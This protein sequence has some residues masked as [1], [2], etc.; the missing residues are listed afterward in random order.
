MNN[1]LLVHLNSAT[2]GVLGLPSLKTVF[3]IFLIENE[4][5]AS[6]FV[7]PSRIFPASF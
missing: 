7:Q 4:A 5:V 2:L 3:G 6:T 1:F